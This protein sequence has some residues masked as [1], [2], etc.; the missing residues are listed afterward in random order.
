MVLGTEGEI[1]VRFIV[2][3]VTVI[4]IIIEWS[5]MQESSCLILISFWQR[6]ENPCFI[7]VK[8]GYLGKTE[9]IV[10]SEVVLV[11]NHHGPPFYKNIEMKKLKILK[12]HAGQ[13]S[14]WITYILKEPELSR[15]N[16]TLGLLQPRTKW[17]AHGTAIL[18]T[19]VEGICTVGKQMG[20][21]CQQETAPN[22]D[23]G[24]KKVSLIGGEQQ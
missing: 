3:I 17:R 5:K 7:W 10:V 14:G 1:S 11:L 12:S 19:V 20:L 8:Q 21:A 2:G 18:S 9:Y 6:W 4:H 24:Y 16:I 23:K 15:F 13:G 22:L